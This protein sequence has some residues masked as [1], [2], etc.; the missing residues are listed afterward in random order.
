MSE[1]GEHQFV[2]NR[3]FSLDYVS[4]GAV[5]CAYPF[6]DF[7][8]FEGSAPGTTDHRAVHAHSS[9][10]SAESDVQLFPLWTAGDCKVVVVAV[11]RSSRA[12]STAAYHLCSRPLGAVVTSKGDSVGYRAEQIGQL[13][14]CDVHISFDGHKNFCCDE[15]RYSSQNRLVDLCFKRDPRPVNR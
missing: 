15:R 7:Y 11:D 4:D 5:Y 3:A 10:F 8:H 2:V 9:L 6:Q 12:T 14:D 13:F 1:I